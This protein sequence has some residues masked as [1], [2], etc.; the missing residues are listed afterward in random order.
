[1]RKT[2]IAIS[3]VVIGL[4]VLA[5]FNVNLL[6][7]RNK[8]YLL[9]RLRQSLGQPVRAASLSVS[10]IPFALSAQSI[11]VGTDLAN[12]IV[13]AKSLRVEP[14]ILP[15]LLGQLRAAHIAMDTPVIII[16]RDAAGRYNFQPVP[17]SSATAATGPGK[18][19]KTSGEQKEFFIP[20]M[21]IS[22]GT[23]RYR[24]ANGDRELTVTEIDLTVSGY[25]I[26]LPVEI[27]L[28]AAVMAAKPNLKLKSRIGPIANI[29]DYRDYPLDGQLNAAQLDLGKINQALPRFRKALP[30]HLRFDG[31]YDITDLRFKGSLNKPALKGAVKGTDASF[32]F[33]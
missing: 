5:A 22:H 29:R 17:V 3:I 30:K 13:R 25:D 16:L 9:G 32:R 20:P 2:L 10:F 31:I 24:D 15:L 11:E 8:D 18:E 1:M 19:E 33:E 23:L 14:R 7:E 26:E 6:V 4:L 27:E 12:P 21:E 28:S